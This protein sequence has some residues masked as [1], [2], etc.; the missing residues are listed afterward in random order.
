MKTWPDILACAVVGTERQSLAVAP[1]DELHV[2]LAQTDEADREGRLLRAAALAALYRR[3]GFLPLSETHARGEVC[4]PDDVPRCGAV[5]GGHL[6]LMLEGEFKEVLPEWLRATRRAGL[7]VPEEHLPSLLDKGESTSALRALIV[8]VAGRRGRW[9]AAQNPAWHYARERSQ[10]EVWET[11]ARDERLLFIE[12]LR[13]REPERARELIISTWSEESSKERVA[14]LEKLAEG[15]SGADEAF[16][17]EAASADRSVEV[18]RAARE[19]LARLPE[20]QFC[21]RVEASAGRL[22]A[23]KKP[24][25]GRARIDVAMPE[26]FAA[27]LTEQGLEIELPKRDGEAAQTLGPK[28]WGLREV[29]GL[30]PVAYWRAKWNRTAPEIIRAAQ[31]S[32]WAEALTRGF[33]RAAR[34]DGTPDWIEAIIRQGLERKD[35]RPDVKQAWTGFAPSLPVERLETLIEELLKADAQGLRDGQPA[36][37][38]LVEHRREW[39]ER[40]SRAVV[41]SIRKRI[42]LS[43]AGEASDW[44]LKSVLKQFARYASPLVGDEAA[45]DW[46]TDAG[47]WPQWENTVGSFV[48]L[49]RFRRAMLDAIFE[50]EQKT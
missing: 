32:E 27:W 41:G 35:T 23:F 8:A 10:G 48:A 24:M 22:L 47:G 28:G 29:V 20:S 6:S 19:M 30:T 40:F 16:L 4:E 11:G 39:S 7:R 1:D 31:E 50:G 46:P 33:A 37:W 49:L 15:L 5:A 3:A 45:S 14:F 2:L 42:R 12:G 38:L 17:S 34:R 13:A 43:V 44:H 26:D 9:L 25:L 18:R 21:R 36:L